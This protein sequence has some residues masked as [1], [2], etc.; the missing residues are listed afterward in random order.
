M[1]TP[2]ITESVNGA[3][4][5]VL[6]VPRSSKT[7]ITGI[8]QDRCKIKVKAPPVEGEANIALIKAISKYF[9]IPKK[10]VI[11]QNGLTGKQK[12]FL[13]LSMN[14]EK[15]EAILQDILNKLN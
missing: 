3:L 14:A 10:H 9:S 13:L 12:T 5:H 4:L 8:Y 1:T 11:Q 7:E 15:A 2:C 6:A